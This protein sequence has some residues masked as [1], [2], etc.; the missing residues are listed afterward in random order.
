VQAV[1]NPEWRAEADLIYQRYALWHQSGGAEQRIFDQA[2]G[3]ATGRS[4]RIF[5]RLVRDFL[6][7]EK[8]RLL[9]IGCGNGSLLR[10]AAE[11]LPDWRLAG[12]EFDNKHR[13]PIEAIP[14]VEQL[15]IGP[16]ENVPGQFD[17]IMLS[18]VFEH[19]TEPRALLTTLT[20]LLKPGGCLFIQV[21]NYAE[22][23]FELLIADHCTHF[24]PVSLGGV[25]AGAGFTI[26]TL[27]TDWVPREISLV[28]HPGNAPG[29]LPPPSDTSAVFGQVT[30]SL[31][32]LDRLRAAAIDACAPPFGI[33][34][35]SIAGT[36]LYGELQDR[37]SFFVDEDPQR[38][39]KSHLGLPILLPEGVPSDGSVFVALPDAIA[40]TIG[41]RLRRMTPRGVR[42]VTLGKS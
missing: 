3:Q 27:A 34:G 25:V 32:W 24:C 26:K 9:D 22:N 41:L 2:S 38:A 40:E 11:M 21:P 12:T 31:A 42:V 35:T 14:G 39:G 33:F 36:W 8:G 5:E 23:P 10:V 1:T 6:L 13:A 19:W 20:R 16:L 15:Y 30:G 29:T 28:A 4:R 17:L 7:Q 37:V 18:H